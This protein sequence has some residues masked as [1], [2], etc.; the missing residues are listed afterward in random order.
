M[1]PSG[2]ALM[3]D[4]KKSK[5]PQRTASGPRTI[6]GKQHSRRNRLSHGIC[7]R[8]L[9]L[10]DEAAEFS[11]THRSFRKALDP[12]GGPEDYLVFELAMV[13]L[14]KIRLRKAETAEIAKISSF[15]HRDRLQEQAISAT[16]NR[17]SAGLMGAYAN[18]IASN[19]AV[20]ILKTLRV[21][22]EKRGYDPIQDPATLERVYG[23]DRMEWGFARDYA[24]LARLAGDSQECERQSQNAQDL[25]RQVLEATDG[26]IKRISGDA[27]EIA[28]VETERLN[29]VAQSALVAPPEVLDRL[30]R[31]DA[32]LDRQFRRMLN[33][34][35]RLQGARRGTSDIRTINILRE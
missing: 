3:T 6:A 13:V 26:E 9:L 35:E 28:K 10:P 17:S 31:Y 25:R 34:L 15:V 1:A 2:C 18:P 29:Y 12:V 24:V 16:E 27:G 19:C 21:Q 5:L 23:P 14:R 7:A 11:S 30:L 4:S 20:E 32:H 22:F 33:D 8:E